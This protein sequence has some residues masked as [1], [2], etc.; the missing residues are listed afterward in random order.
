MLNEFGVN[1]LQTLKERQEWRELLAKHAVTHT[2]GYSKISGQAEL[3]KDIERP[4]LLSTDFS[5]HWS[6]CW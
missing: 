5:L 4:L 3:D 1:S 6:V 2:S